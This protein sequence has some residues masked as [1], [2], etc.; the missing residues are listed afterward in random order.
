MTADVNALIDRFLL[1]LKAQRNL[2]EHSIRAYAIDLTQFAAWLEKEQLAFDAIDHRIIRRY[3]AN[4]TAAQYARS[5][6]NR[7]LSSTKTFYR[8]L[9]STGQLA[10]DPTSVISGPKQMRALPKLVRHDE[11]ERLLE[12]PKEVETP[13]ELRDRA[14]IELIYA[15]GARI[16]E[17]SSLKVGDIFGLL[18]HTA[19]EDFSFF[20][21][22]LSITR[23]RYPSVIFY[24][25]CLIQC[26][27]SM[28]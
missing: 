24:L 14:L 11:L 12:E 15:T 25:T 4:L 16:S 26:A 20:S 27:A 22:S 8:W 18:T 28:A 9:V 19:P 13:A 23:G 5:T 7:R 17:V 6:I 21:S 2:S 1:M 10:A 3:L